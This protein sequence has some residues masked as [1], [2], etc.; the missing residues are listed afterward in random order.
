ML[1]TISN[2]LSGLPEVVSLTVNLFYNDIGRLV[3]Y[4]V[5]KEKVPQVTKN[6]FF[7]IADSSISVFVSLI[8]FIAENIGQDWRATTYGIFKPNYGESWKEVERRV[9]ALKS[10]IDKAVV[11]L[12]DVDDKLHK[13][14]SIPI[15]SESFHD[16]PEDVPANIFR[17]GCPAFERHVYNDNKDVNEI[18]RYFDSEDTIKEFRSLTLWGG[19]RIDERYVSFHYG[20]TRIRNKELDAMFWIDS[21]KE[22]T[23]Y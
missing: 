14:Q 17:V 12:D 3:K 20:D 7:H 21:E 11:L 13:L 1:T 23:I 19:R 4:W 6:V 2:G 22:S 15:A 18:A 9:N 5:S 8:L 10:D 16:A